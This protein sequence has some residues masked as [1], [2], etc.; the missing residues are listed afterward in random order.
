MSTEITGNLI[1]Q[2]ESISAE[3][4]LPLEK[5]LVDTAVWFHHNKDR[6]PKHEVEKKVE[7]LTVALDIFIEMTALLVDRMQ[8]VEGRSKSASLWL[9]NGM[10]DKDTGKRFG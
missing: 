4:H 8:E 5:R 6:I 10:V 9:P 7:F 2:L 3:T 1:K